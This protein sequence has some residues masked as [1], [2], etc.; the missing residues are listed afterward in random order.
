M[1][2]E[3]LE[4]K[5]LLLIMSLGSAALLLASSV[6]DFARQ[7]NLN[8]KN[9]LGK[10]FVW[11]YNMGWGFLIGY[12]LVE[13]AFRLAEGYDGSF[14][15]PI[16]MLTVGFA[17]FLLYIIVIARKDPDVQKE[18]SLAKTD[19]RMI[20]N[21]HKAHYYAYYTLLASLVIFATTIG[22]MS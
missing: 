6:M 22:I 2:V 8:K 12:G 19:E 15:T 20:A 4:G 1:E 13:I 5:F 16:I 14:A 21:N 7:P 11:I 3:K 18:F 9:F 10:L 17:M